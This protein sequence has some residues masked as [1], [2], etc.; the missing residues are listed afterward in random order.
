MT[1]GKKI[2]C[3]AVVLALLVSVFGCSKKNSMELDPQMKTNI[4]E[5]V[6]MGV[7]QEVYTKYGKAPGITVDKIDARDASINDYYQILFTATGSYTVVADKDELYTGTFTID[8]HWEAHGCG[9]GECKLTA[10]KNGLKTLPENP[11]VMETEAATDTTTTTEPTETTI[12][13]PLLDYI[14]ANTSSMGRLLGKVYESDV[15]QD[16][17]PD[18]CVTVIYGS[19]I[20]SSAIVVYDVKN[21]KGYILDERMTCDYEILG[22]D[23]DLVAVCRTAY[24]KDGKTYGVLAIEGDNLVFIENEEIGATTPVRNG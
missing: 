19:G 3:I 1:M 24:G 2:A 14:S 10:P 7:H 8:G 13:Q 15:N 11:V 12:Y 6:K 9:T 5:I 23:K 4:E 18:L 22:A 17:N 20:I 21:D 16:G